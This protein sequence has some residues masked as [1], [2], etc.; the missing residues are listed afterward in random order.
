[1][2]I[3]IAV[4]VLL[5][6]VVDISA[7]AKSNQ[8]ADRSMLTD[9]L[10]PGEA[11]DDVRTSETIKTKDTRQAFH[12]PATLRQW[13][14]RKAELRRRIMVSAGLWPMPEKTDLHPEVFD[15]KQ[16]ET[17]TVEKVMLET[18]PGY[19]LTGNLYRP[20]QT[21]AGQKFP[22]ILSPHGHWSKGRL[23]DADS[24]SMLRR[25][26]TLAMQG[27]VCFSYDMVGYADNRYLVEMHRF[28]GESLGLWGLTPGGLQLWNSIRALDFVAS[29]DEVDPKAIGCTGASGGGSQ[30]FLLAAVDDRI[31]AAAPV[32]MISHIMQ[33]GCMCENM[34]QLRLDT[35]NVELAALIA[36][37]PLIMVCATGDWTSTT[38]QIEYPA[39]QSV[40][41]L[42]GAEDRLVYRMQDAPHNYNK[43]SREHVYA[44]FGKQFFPE[45]PAEAFREPDMKL[46][47]I[48][49]LAVFARRDPP[50]PNFGLR[51]LLEYFRESR[52]DQLMAAL[53]GDRESF[54]RGFG[55]AYRMTLAVSEPAA[56]D[57]R[58]QHHGRS[59][60]PIKNVRL[61]KFLIRN[62]R[63]R[64]SVP[65]NLWLPKNHAGKEPVLLIDPKGKRALIGPDG[66][67]CEVLAAYLK[68]GQPVLGI[69][70]FGT[71]EYMSRVCFWDEY[72]FDLLYNCY[73]LPRAAN[74]IQDILLAESYLA[75][76]FSQPARIVGL[77]GAGGCV[78]LAHGLADQ[79]AGTIADL[80]GVS[81][82]Q[83]AAFEGFHVSNIRRA[84]DFVSSIVVGGARPVECRNNPDPVFQ[85]RLE[86]AKALA[87]R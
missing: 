18:Y 11:L 43:V 78:L 65:A 46:D 76:R 86:K 44:W 84:G 57:I 14:E 85:R 83:D 36:P 50:E 5:L 48:A 32:C 2:M 81:L 28:Q 26:A 42:Y 77:E 38:A 69:D 3:R 45:R 6:A 87:R 31:S 71:G 80:K 22:A 1:M 40:Y 55:V 74:R 15:R 82:S 62:T 53:N 24:G 4:A 58:V 12:A 23:S 9:V 72:D 52:E 63:T 56:D 37:R 75:K 54:M 10:E 51:G 33:G 35:N 41:R 13:E 30:T 19:Y 17:Y 59:D 61:E 25:A 68:R 16:H 49:D 79:S 29:L 21:R 60:S 39:I 70:C 7:Q 47:P 27:Y 67:P 20:R 34:P 66:A 8:L 64:Q 73:N